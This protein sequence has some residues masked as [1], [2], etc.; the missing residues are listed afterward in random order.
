MVPL[1]QDIAGLSVTSGLHRR[2]GIIFAYEY[3]LDWIDVR[4]NLEVYTKSHPPEHWP[5]C[6]V[7]LDKGMFFW[8]TEKELRWRSSDLV[9]LKQ[10]II[11][12][13]PDQADN[14]F[15]R[16]YEVLLDLL[17]SSTTGTPELSTYSKYPPAKPGAL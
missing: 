10:P 11:H 15:L 3:V 6:V 2:F 4:N 7:I 16:F 17:K 8:G 14:V 9:N 12:G 13:I 1:T 5:N